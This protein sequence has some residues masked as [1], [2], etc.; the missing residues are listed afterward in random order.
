[1][2]LLPVPRDQQ[3]EEKEHGKVEQLAPLLGEL[4]AVF[5]GFLEPHLHRQPG[6]ER[7]DEHARADGFGRQQ[8]KQ[9]QRDHA[10]LL[11]RFRH[12]LLAARQ[13][14]QPAAGQADADTD[15]RA[16]AQLFDDES[17]RLAR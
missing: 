15:E 14:Q 17:V 1:M 12:P 4:D 11:K 3:A 7:G 9:R 2:K 13:A 5:A 8:A 16:V 10:E 6:D